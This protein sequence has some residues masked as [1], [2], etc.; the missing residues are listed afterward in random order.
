MY[1]KPAFDQNN[2]PVIFNV[3]ERYVAYLSVALQSIVD[4]ASNEHNY[5]LI[6]LETGLNN[7]ARNR[8]FAQIEGSHNISLRF[9]DMA[10]IAKEY[11]VENWYSYPLTAAAYY[12]LFIPVICQNFQKVI[13]LDSDVLVRRDLAALYKVDLGFKLLAGVR[14]FGDIH[15]MDGMVEFDGIQ[16]SKADYMRKI[17]L[18]PDPAKYINSGVL[19]LN[20]TGMRNEDCLQRFRELAQKGCVQHDQDVLNSVC[21]GRIKYLDD[22]WNA[23]WHVLFNT[24]AGSMPASEVEAVLGRAKII[25]YIVIRPHLAPNKPFGAPW[26]ECARKT[27]YYDVLLHEKEAFDR[28]RG[29]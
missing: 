15:L 21:R 1:P 17:L 27:P 19:V 29:Q 26:L 3:D 8:L 9:F 13:Y 5:D 24:T 7:E 18:I 22:G 10:P 11:G 16:M 4:T 28:E 25:H 12:R 23:Q 20:V 2:I 6:I 14:D